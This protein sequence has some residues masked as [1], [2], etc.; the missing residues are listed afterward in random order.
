MYSIVGI[1][2]ID[3]VSKKTNQRVLGVE[4]HCIEEVKNVDGYAVE[5]FYLSENLL[6]NCGVDPESIVIDACFEASYNKFGK[7]AHVS[8]HD[9]KEA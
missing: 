6:N 2:K 1:R 9:V 8:F 3:Y 5:K 4:L 7:I